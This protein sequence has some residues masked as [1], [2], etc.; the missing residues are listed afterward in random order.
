MLEPVPIDVDVDAILA[1]EFDTSFPRLKDELDTDNCPLLDF[2][3][4]VFDTLFE[5]FEQEGCLFGKEDA[6]SSTFASFEQ[7]TFDPL[8]LPA[9]CLAPTPKR[10]KRK[11]EDLNDTTSEYTKC[12]RISNAP[13]T[14]EGE[15]STKSESIILDL[16]ASPR[17]TWP[18]AKQNRF[19]AMQRLHAKRLEG[20]FGLSKKSRFR[21]TLANGRKRTRKGQFART[22]KFKW[23]SVCDL[24]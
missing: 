3:D 20:R 18:L 9:E 4:S 5:D 21:Q 22:S 24:Q 10:E 16:F 1:P 17:N 7:N 8:V 14:V 15:V 11:R 19:D 13:D 6:K 2:D 12:F 23:V